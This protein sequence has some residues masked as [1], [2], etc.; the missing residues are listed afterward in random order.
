MAIKLNW[1]RVKQLHADLTSDGWKDTDKLLFIL[2]EKGGQP[3]KT[4]VQF[5]ELYKFFWH[6]MDDE[7]LKVLTFIVQ[8]S[9]GKV[10]YRHRQVV[11]NEEVPNG[12]HGDLISHWAALTEDE[13]QTYITLLVAQIDAYER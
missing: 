5:R 13:K 4:T 11:G 10:L 2:I 12:G 6:L 3:K 8:D 9:E 1:D 7:A